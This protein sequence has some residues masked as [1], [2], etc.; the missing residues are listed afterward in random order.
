MNMA[1][2]TK[3]ASDLFRQKWFRQLKP[4]HKLLWL[5]LT[6]ESNI[7]GVFEIDAASW[8]FFIG[9]QVRDEDVFTKFGKRFQRLP[10]HPEKGVQVGKLDYQAAFGR[11]STQ[12][13]W[14][15]RE[16]EAVGL[17]YEKLQEMKSHEEEQLELGLEYPPEKP[18]E[19]PQEELRHTIPPNPEWV[20]AYIAENGYKVDAAKFCDFYEAKGWKIGKNKMKDWQAA[21]RTWAEDGEKPA[22]PKSAVVQNLRRK[23]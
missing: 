16:L 2:K 22:K 3:I 10:K 5:Y 21:V 20:R 17:T 13:K 6:V 7:V 18:T 15:E 4:E 12:W 19:P 9:T 1:V 11:N 8:S 23:F 14:V